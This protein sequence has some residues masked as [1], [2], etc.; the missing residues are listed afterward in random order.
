MEHEHGLVRLH[1]LK[2]VDQ[3]ASDPSIKRSHH[4]CVVERALS[5]AQGRLG[6]VIGALESVQLAARN[7]AALVQLTP[8]GEFVVSLVEIGARRVHPG[9]KIG[10]IKTPQQFA[11]F[12]NHPLC[13]GK[14][15]Q[16]PRH[17]E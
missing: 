6:H 8:P 1:V 16:P 7:D 17:I 4:A 3:R 10:F 14:L 5:L 11:E 2:I 13:G 9:D 15:D 12:E